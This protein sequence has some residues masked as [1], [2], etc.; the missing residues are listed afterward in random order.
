[1]AAPAE[2]ISYGGSSLLLMEETIKTRS[3]DF[4]DGTLVYLAPSRDSFTEGATAPGYPNMVITD[5]DAVGVQDEWRCTLT[6][7]GLRKGGQRM[8]SRVV[9]PRREG[10]DD[11]SEVWVTKSPNSFSINTALTGYA[12]MKCIECT[13]EDLRMGGW[14]RVS[15]RFAGSAGSKPYKRVYGV[16]RQTVQPGVPIFVN[17]PGGWTDA[18][19]SRV[20]LPQIT[21]TD[22][23]V[24][25]ERPAFTNIPRAETPP[26]APAV[27]DLVNFG[28]VTYQWPSGWTLIAQPFDPIPGTNIGILQKQ[29][30][31]KYP[32]TL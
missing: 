6:I 32:T 10:L 3:N 16:N 22:I 26:D 24:V 7:R 14:N 25:T 28:D 17:Y 9:T 2:V 19:K 1:M 23:Y 8:L 13:K 21:I 20:D 29:Y 5:I 18:R 30:E 27:T 15:L 12:N 11:A 4:D 31:F